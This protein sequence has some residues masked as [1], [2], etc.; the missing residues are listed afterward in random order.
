MCSVLQCRVVSHPQYPRAMLIVVLQ[1]HK[2]GS[3]LNAYWDCRLHHYTTIRCRVCQVRTRTIYEASC[4]KSH[5]RADLSAIVDCVAID[6][7]LLFQT[8]A[9]CE[10]DLPRTVTAVCC[11]TQQRQT[12]CLSVLLGGTVLLP[13]PSLHTPTN[14]DVSV[15]ERSSFISR[16]LDEWNE[17]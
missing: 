5:A 17:E 14:Y 8:E 2:F 1:V 15:C 10:C 13:L 9:S 16:W 4:S 12:H 6:R 11:A 3:R 7:L